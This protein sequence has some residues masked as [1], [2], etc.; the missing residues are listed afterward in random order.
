[1]TRRAGSWRIGRDRL[2]FLTGAAGISG[3]AWIYLAKMSSGHLHGHA[4]FPVAFIMWTIMMIAM[5]LPSALPFVM[6]FAGEHRRRRERNLPYVPAGV[7]LAGY[8]ALWTA[9]SALAAGLQQVWHD[10]AALSSR[11]PATV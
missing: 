8:F 1:M 9:F 3:A 6:A 7:F 5:M 11:I 4:V 2:I 10:E